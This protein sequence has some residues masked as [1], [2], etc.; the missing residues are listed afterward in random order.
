MFTVRH[1]HGGV[2]DKNVWSQRLGS[3]SC[4]KS[5][6]LQ[7]QLAV[8]AYAV[9]FR[10]C[11]VWRCV[12]LRQTRRILCVLTT[13]SD[14]ARASDSDSTFEILLGRPKQARSAWAWT[15]AMPLM[16]DCD[17]PW[18]AGRLYHRSLTKTALQILRSAKIKD[19]HLVS[20]RSFVTFTKPLSLRLSLLIQ[21]KALSMSAHW[22][23]CFLVY[24]ITFPTDPITHLEC[25]FRGS[26]LLLA[27]RQVVEDR[28]NE[29]NGGWY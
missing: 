5:I 29:D 7:K 14:V 18:S 2:D 28:K 27:F 22:K 10:W 1:S 15:I 3:S 20:P 17:T 21:F 23:E 19:P 12:C 6:R 16:F 11:S 9:S 8:M 4:N 24:G 13:P 26:S 25:C